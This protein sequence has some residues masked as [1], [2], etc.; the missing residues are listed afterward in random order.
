VEVGGPVP[1][2]R[3]E[4]AQPPA[5]PL[6]GLAEQQVGQRRVAGQHRAVQVGAEHGALPGPL[7]GVP[8]VVAAAADDPAERL[9]AGT[10]DRAPA[11]V[12]EP[13]Q[14]LTLPAHGHHLAHQPRAVGG[15]LQVEQAQPADL[16]PSW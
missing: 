12:L 10:Q 7:G 1:A 8:A 3:L 15:G 11:V 2:D 13:G 16:L 5:S 4:R 14:Q 9:D 6:E